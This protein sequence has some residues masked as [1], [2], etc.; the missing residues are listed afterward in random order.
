[1]KA[2]YEPKNTSATKANE[3]KTTDAT[4]ANEPKPTKAKKW[5]LVKHFEGEPK[6]SDLQ[7]TEEDLP[8][9]KDGGMWFF[10]CTR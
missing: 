10:T 7:L 2:L 6:D 3:P 8:E 4:K 5:V 1:M 9:V